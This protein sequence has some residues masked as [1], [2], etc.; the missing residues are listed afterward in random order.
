MLYVKVEQ[1]SKKGVA[2]AEGS[3]QRAASW[4]LLDPLRASTGGRSRWQDPE[5][6]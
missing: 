2:S 1:C 3:W 6:I 4:D 5:L